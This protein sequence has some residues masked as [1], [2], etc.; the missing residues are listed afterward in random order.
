MLLEA[1][2]IWKKIRAELESKNIILS[3]NTYDN[4]YAKEFDGNKLVLEIEDRESFNEIYLNQDEI[5]KNL[6][7]FIKS[8]FDLDENLD[9]E[10]VKLYNEEAF[11]VYTEY[12]KNDVFKSGIDENL[13]FENYV[14]SD[15]NIHAFTLAQ[16]I[17]SGNIEY[18]PLVI[19]GD[20]GF[21]K[22]HLANAVGNEIMKKDSKKKILYI[23]STE[24]SNELVLSFQNK[25]TLAFKEK[26]KNL[27]GLIVDDIQFF[28]GIFGKGDDKIQKEF[29]EAF[30]SLHKDNKPIIL[31]SDRYPNQIKNVENRLVSRFLAG[32][33][34]EI[35]KPDKSI[36]VS[37]IKIKIK[38]SNVEI[39][40]DLI[41]YMAEN[42][43]TNIREIDGFLKDLLFYVTFGAKPNERPRITKELIDE[44]LK[45]RI[46]Q[47]KNEITKEK[48][49]EITTDYYELKKDDVLGKSRKKEFVAARHVIIYIL[50]TKLE[51]GM[52]EIGK[53][54]DSDHS[55][56][57]KSIQKVA[58][59]I[60]KNEKDELVQDLEKI[61][62]LLES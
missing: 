46:I 22:T 53:V 35:K 5:V 1:S 32:S 55:T 4:V 8:I 44:Q 54:F 51:M 33:T 2:K 29:Y 42:L 47:K 11:D 3:S 12:V 62:K 28:E 57:T 26:F 27:D 60:S 58:G 6:N 59:I 23:T 10:L 34:I 39:D 36:R 41:Y 21:G 56:I 14:V 16:S 31:I 18:S 9:L 15:N 13:T 43:D 40:D 20:P 61:T 19:Y 30:N 24:F 50:A 17:A 49:I 52:K 38:K 37:I 48:V 45:R 25:T 7:D